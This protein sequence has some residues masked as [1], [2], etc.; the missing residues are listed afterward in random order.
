MKPVSILAVIAAIASS[1]YRDSGPDVP[2]GEPKEP[3]EP[4]VMT[5]ASD[6][7][8]VSE[9]Q[10]KHLPERPVFSTPQPLVPR[11]PPQ[12]RRDGRRPQFAQWRG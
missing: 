9:S 11:R 5:V 4:T 8:G 1:G 12:S 7:H 6:R 2:S 3:P 10:Q